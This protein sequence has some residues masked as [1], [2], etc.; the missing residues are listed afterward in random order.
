MNY[1]TKLQWVLYKPGI[2]PDTDKPSTAYS[3]ARFLPN[4]YITYWNTTRIHDKPKTR[5]EVTLKTVIL[6]SVLKGTF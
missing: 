3:N 6:M 4:N 1:N 5:K 2:S